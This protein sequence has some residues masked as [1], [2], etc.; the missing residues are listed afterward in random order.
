MSKPGHFIIQS[1]CFKAQGDVGPLTTYTNKRGIV[2]FLKAWLRDPA[3][4]KQIAHRDRIR[5]CAANWKDAPQ[6]TRTQYEL[7]TKRAT[8]Y[9]NGYNLWVAAS[10]TQEA[11]SALATL[12]RQTG[13]ALPTPPIE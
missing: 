8:L 6:T 3:S 7:A 13:T 5:R 4:R 12:E 2:V 10:M 11:R 1:I 9:I